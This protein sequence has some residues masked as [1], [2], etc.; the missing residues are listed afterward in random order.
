MLISYPLLI[1]YFESV[2]VKNL[3]QRTFKKLTD[4]TP[5]VLKRDYKDL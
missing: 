3:I 2:L 5:S 4:E 1:S